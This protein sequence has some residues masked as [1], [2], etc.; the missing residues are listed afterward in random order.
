M[1]LEL[2]RWRSP[3]TSKVRESETSQLLFEASQ[4]T[5]AYT[6]Y[7]EKRICM[8]ADTSVCWSIETFYGFRNS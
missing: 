8:Q 3:N 1:H 6:I 5:C 2:L 4:S 7:A